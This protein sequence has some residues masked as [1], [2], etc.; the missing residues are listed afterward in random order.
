MSYARHR[1]NT[2]A[3]DKEWSFDCRVPSPKQSEEAM[4]RDHRRITLLTQ[5]KDF[6]ERIWNHSNEAGS[7]IVLL[8]S[9]AMLR[10]TIL[11]PLVRSDSDLERI[12]L[13][14]CCSE[15][16]FLS[17]LTELPLEFSGDVVMIREGGTTEGGTNFLSAS[18]R[19]GGRL[20]YALSDEDI[21]FYLE[22]VRLVDRTE[23]MERGVLQF[24]P[25]IIEKPRAQ[26]GNSA[27]QPESGDDDA[28]I[29]RNS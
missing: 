2:L 8:D 13:D 20:L 29:R 9:L 22:T 21:E 17:L 16:E 27:S 1:V 4:S 28:R 10:S 7:K 23:E 19:G 6:S 25:R 12:I 26:H 18:G 15:S 3:R 24:R 11:S 14:R 5:S